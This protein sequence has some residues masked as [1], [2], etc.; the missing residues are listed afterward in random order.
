MTGNIR[1][2]IVDDEVPARRRLQ[3][4]LAEEADVEIVGEASNGLLA[5]EAI[6]Q[7][8]PDLVF[9]DVQMPELDGFGVVQAIG[10]DAMPATVFVTAYDHYAL[11]AFDANAIDYLLKPFDQDRFRR[12]MRRVRARLGR[13]REDALQSQL[14]NV[15]DGLSKDRKYPDRLLVRTGES[16]QLVRLADLH[17]VTAEG[18]YVR[19]HTS[20]GA[21]LMRESM[22]GMEARLDPAIFRRIHRSSIVNID[23]IGKLL[24]WFGGDYLVMMADGGKLTLS[25]NFRAA[26]G[27]YLKIEG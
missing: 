20:T 13:E 15:L 25:R 16:R 24:P 17:Y 23:H 10:T 19:L 6:E 12:T 8:Q 7:L 26:L 22:R 3:Q 4:F 9:L 27:E 14:L 1:A 18:N 2:L 11:P 5:V 21:H